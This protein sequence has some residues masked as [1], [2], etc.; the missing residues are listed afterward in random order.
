MEG[1]V[2]GGRSSDACR[3]R[4]ERG[5]ARRASGGGVRRPIGGRFEIPNGRQLAEGGDERGYGRL[6]VTEDHRAT[7][8]VVEE[9]GGDGGV[10]SLGNAGRRMEGGGM[11]ARFRNGRTHAAEV[12][13]TRWSR[14]GGRGGNRAY[15]RRVIRRIDIVGR[16]RS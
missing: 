2:L 8:E 10:V 14:G 3:R 12:T 13:R 11:S 9:F 5:R 1:V 7:L 15:H 4:R 16:V 6:V